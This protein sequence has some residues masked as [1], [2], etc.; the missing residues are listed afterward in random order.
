MNLPSEQDST[1]LEPYEEE[2][3]FL[4][5]DKEI[6]ETGYEPTNRLRSMVDWTSI[7]T[8]YRVRK[9]FKKIIKKLV[10]KGYLDDHGKRGEVASLTK[11]GVRFVLGKL[12]SVK[13]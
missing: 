7:R 4:L 6:I 9:G 13:E 12:N 3:L 8:K 10:K 11:T 5:Y 2:I 1:P